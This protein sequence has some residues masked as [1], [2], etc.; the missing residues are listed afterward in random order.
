MAGQQFTTG[1]TEMLQAV[2]TM[3]DVNQQLQGSLRALQG[4][5]EQVAGAW[6]G[7]A[8]TAFANLMA[9]FNEDATK[10]NNDLQQISE[11]VSGNNKTYQANEENAQ[12]SISGIM[13]GL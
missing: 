12:S 7:S 1:S 5:V 3:E 6:K 2:K 8:A 10:L 4:E 9:R 11:A 13:N